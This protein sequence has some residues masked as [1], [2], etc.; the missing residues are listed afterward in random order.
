MKKFGKKG[1]G[2]LYGI[3][4]CDEYIDTSR[5]SGNISYKCNYCKDTYRGDFIYI[6]I[7]GTEKTCILKR[8]QKG[9]TDCLKEWSKI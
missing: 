1:L 9:G 7:F 4:I 6:I 2:V 5:N 8:E 3:Y